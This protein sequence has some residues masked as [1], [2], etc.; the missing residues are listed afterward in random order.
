[1]YCYTKIST[2]NIFFLKI[3]TKTSI[4][5]HEPPQDTGDN[6]NQTTADEVLF[7][8]AGVRNFLSMFVT[9]IVTAV[10]MKEK[11]DVRNRGTTVLGS[12]H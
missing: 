12:C 8:A 1:M 3:Q 11:L 9:L 6:Q 7:L 10:V 2:K 4:G 5:L